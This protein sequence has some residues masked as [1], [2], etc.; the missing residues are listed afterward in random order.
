MLSNNDVSFTKT[1]CETSHSIRIKVF[2]FFSD[3][4]VLF[5]KLYIC[6]VEIHSLSINN[7]L[8]SKRSLYVLMQ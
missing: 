7:G 5:K 3:I 4:S 6:E 1:A 8:S 2:S